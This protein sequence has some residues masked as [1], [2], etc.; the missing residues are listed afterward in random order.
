MHDRLNSQGS[1]LLFLPLRNI[2]APCVKSRG[3]MT[4]S[5]RITQSVVGRSL[6][7]TVRLHICCPLQFMAMALRWAVL[8]CARGLVTGSGRSIA[9]S[10]TEKITDVTKE[11]LAVKSSLVIRSTDDLSVVPAHPLHTYL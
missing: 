1:F 6:F 4:H 8:R 11:I 3:A 10:S 5:T 9:C 2:S 7:R